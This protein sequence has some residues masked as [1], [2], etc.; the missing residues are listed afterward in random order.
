MCEKTRKR[1]EEEKRKEG[2]RSSENQGVVVTAG[3]EQWY[4]RKGG[5]QSLYRFEDRLQSSIVTILRNPNNLSLVRTTDEQPASRWDRNLQ[6]WLFLRSGAI[7]PCHNEPLEI[8]DFLFFFLIFCA[9]AE[10]KR[11]D[12]KLFTT[13]IRAIT[14]FVI[15]ILS[16]S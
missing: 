13:A 7:S 11:T 12:I 8:V 5:Q 4:P 10:R 15:R 6:P 16:V 9:T 3:R 2:A 14:I 1:S